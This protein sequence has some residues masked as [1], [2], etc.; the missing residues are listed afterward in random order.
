MTLW[1][2]MAV[3]VVGFLVA[4]VVTA[5]LILWAE[6]RALQVTRHWRNAHGMREGR[7]G[8]GEPCAVCG[9]RWEHGVAR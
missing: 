7:T 6:D 1:A 9:T 4:F 8:L 3:L 5:T 2:W